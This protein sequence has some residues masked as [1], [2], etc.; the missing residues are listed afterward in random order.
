[1]GEPA[2]AVGG[3]EQGVGQVNSFS[4][5]QKE[6]VDLEEGLCDLQAGKTQDFETTF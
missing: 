2:I 5:T 1:V 4:L 6:P 3:D